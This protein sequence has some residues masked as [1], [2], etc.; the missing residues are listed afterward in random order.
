EGEIRRRIDEGPFLPEDALHAG[1]VDDVAYEDQVDDKLRGGEHHNR[2]DGDDYARVALTSVGL[3]H[4]PRIAV[5]YASGT[6]TRG[7]SGYDPINGPVAGPGNPLRYNRPGPR[8]NRGTA[9]LA[10]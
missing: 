1:F 3:N 5:I 9:I 4:G 10:R 6:I 8:R 2:L 7:K